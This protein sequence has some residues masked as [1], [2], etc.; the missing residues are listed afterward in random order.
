MCYE[1]RRGSD[2]CVTDEVV[3]GSGFELRQVMT[4]EMEWDGREGV[5]GVPE[6]ICIWGTILP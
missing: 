4:F 5:V 1:G 6:C 3:D 2:G